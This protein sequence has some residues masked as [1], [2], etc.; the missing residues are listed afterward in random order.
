MLYPRVLVDSQLHDILLRAYTSP[1]CIYNG[2]RENFIVRCQEVEERHSTHAAQ[3]RSF[4]CHEG[5]LYTWS[6][7]PVLGA[8]EL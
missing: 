1:S 6:S 5:V 7:R 3:T 4:K 2:Q 8:L